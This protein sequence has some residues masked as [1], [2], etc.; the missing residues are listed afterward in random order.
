LPEGEGPFPAV[1]SC[2]PYHKDD[3]IGALFDFPRQYF[4]QNGFAELIVDFRGTGR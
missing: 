3:L 2:Y 4:A 1:M